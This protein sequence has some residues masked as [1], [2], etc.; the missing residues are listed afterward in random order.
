MANLPAP[1]KD[2]QFVAD[3]V[4]D[5]TSHYKKLGVH[6]DIDAET[7][8]T[9][10]EEASKFLHEHAGPLNRQADEQGCRHEG[11][12]VTTPDGFKELYKEFK[13]SGWAS[14]DG[15]VEYGG[16]GLSYWLQLILGELNT[17]Y[18]PGWSNYPGLT[19]GARELIQHFASTE[20]KDKFLHGL[21]TG[22][23][24]GTMCLTEPHCGT[25]LG[26]VNT[27]AKPNDDGS[28]A[29]TGTK[30]FITSGEHD[31]TENIIHL[32]LAR[33][34][35]APK[36]TKGISLFLVP[37]F[38]LNENNQVG[39]R[40]TL[41]AASIEHKMGLNG[42]ATCVMN[43]DG[44]KGYLIGE[45]NDGLKIMFTMMNGARLNTG[46]QGLSATQ[47]S[48]ESALMYAKERLQMRA[49]TGPKLPNKPAD[50]II[51]HP[52]VRR[53]L[54]TQKAFAEG[55][56][57]MAYF[58]GQQI[59]IIKH[60]KDENE[61]K[62]ADK[63][64]AF[65]TPILKAFLTEV[66]LEATDNGVQIFGGHG[67][68]REHGQEQW[69]RDAKIFTLYEG[70]TGIQALDLT[71]RKMLMMQHGQI[72]EMADIIQDFINNNDTPLND[73]LQNY[74][75][76][77]QEVTQFIV[78]EAQKNPNEVGA[79]SVDYLM[80]SGYVILAYFWAQLHNS[81][82]HNKGQL[83]AEFYSGK[84]KTAKFYFAK[85]LPRCHSLKATIFTG[86]DPLMDF[87]ESEF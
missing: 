42:S 84:Q 33:L 51:V 83:G 4:L 81:A 62:R 26:L 12:T 47:A 72:G 14:L 67:Y 82:E 58:V 57:A 24:A 23:W 77:W 68:I 85:I 79:A 8:M 78:Q 6:D 66:A 59:E 86:A 40:N 56:R 38:L 15:D 35:D 31:L 9:I 37:K 43:F 63:L 87:E 49:A 10:V 71:G 69:H 18:C 36:G 13:E 45:G 3:E 50:P 30:I 80:L 22:E 53:M 28:Y 44:A 64:L 70:T 11:N 1:I 7:F 21:T 16:Q 32:V 76:M 19:H 75:D 73:E 20:L 46:I 34:P 2:I 60:S 48:Y 41:G 25:D 55:N 27:S 5:L 54:L 65:L 17:F 39:E 52:D 29:V 61:V 74:L